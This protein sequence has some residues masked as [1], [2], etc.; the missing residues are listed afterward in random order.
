MTFH[1]ERFR[2]VENIEFTYQLKSTSGGSRI[3]QKGVA[4]PEGGDA[5]LYFGKHFSENCMKMKEIGP[6]GTSLAPPPL[7]PPMPTEIQLITAG[8]MTWHV[9]TSRGHVFYRLATCFKT[10]KSLGDAPD[11]IHQEEKHQSAFWW[12][13]HCSFSELSIIVSSIFVQRN[14]LVSSNQ[15]CYQG[16]QCISRTTV[17]LD[18]SA[19][20]LELRSCRE[21]FH[22]GADTLDS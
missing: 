16:N 2:D 19:T 20:A 13:K 5:N 22:T 1:A 17:K 14:V 6:G 3:F 15:N 9:F 21:V 7:D 10:T 12:K 4:Y 18:W 11:T 8:H